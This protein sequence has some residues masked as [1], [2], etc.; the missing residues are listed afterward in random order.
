MTEGPWPFGD[1]DPRT[2]WW[3]DGAGWG[4][5]VEVVRLAGI[6]LLEG[7]PQW[8]LLRLA[9]VAEEAYLPPGQVVVQQYDRAG[10]VHVLVSGS[11]QI[12]LRVGTEDL[13]VGVLRRPGEVLGW[14]AFR[15]P[16]RYTA[17]VRCEAPSHIVTFPV[18]AFEDVFA[19]D[20]RLAHVVLRRVVTAVAE[21]LERARDLIGALPRRGPVGGE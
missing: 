4:D 20:P 17:T 6:P 8:A 19:Q 18:E 9:M 10:A 15:P 11:V 13:L 16:Y 14:S 7:L 3:E 2:Q 21:R 5:V 12:L 1:G